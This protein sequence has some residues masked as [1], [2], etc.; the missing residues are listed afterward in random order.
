MENAQYPGD[1]WLQRI[2]DEVG[3]LS[4]NWMEAVSMPECKCYVFPKICLHVCM[5]LVMY[6]YCYIILVRDLLVYT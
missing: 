3:D 6:N 1:N 2:G 4:V 5:M